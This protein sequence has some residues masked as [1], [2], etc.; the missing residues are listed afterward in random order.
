MRIRVHVTATLSNCEI[1][2]SVSTEKISLPINLTENLKLKT[3]SASPFAFRPGH[4]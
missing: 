3:L 2:S 1:Q 4:R